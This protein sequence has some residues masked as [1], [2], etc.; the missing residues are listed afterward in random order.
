MALE[1]P[2]GP[3]GRWLAALDAGEVPVADADRRELRQALTHIAGGAGA[4][5]DAADP[6]LLIRV[7]SASVALRRFLCRHPAAVAELSALPPVRGVAAWRARLATATARAGDEATFGAALRI[8][9]HRAMLG[10]VARELVEGDPL[11]TGRD[12]SGLAEAALQVT[13]ERWAGWLRRSY[14]EPRLSDGT[15]CRPVVIA[16]GK[17]GGRELNLSSDIDL[18]YAYTADNGRTTGAGGLGRQVDLHTYFSRLF[19]KV[20]QTLAKETA[21]GL[22]FR[23]D[24][25]L[26]PEGRT[27]PVCNSVDG[28]ERYYESFG[29]PWER[30]AWIK[31]RAV[32]GDVALGEA[33]L[34][35]LAPFV[36]RKHLDHHFLG[37]IASMRRRIDARGA[38]LVQRD[39]FDV[40][41]GRGGIREVEFSVQTLQLTWGGKDPALRAVDTTR[42]IASLTAAGYIEAR[43]GQA[44]AAAYRF[45]RR[46]E[47]ALQLRDDRQVQQLGGDPGG[48]KRVAVALGYAPDDQGLAAFEQ[49]LGAHRRAARAAFDAIAAAPAATAADDARRAWEIAF[50][51]ALDPDV[52]QAS[53]LTAVGELG[54]RDAATAL[55]HLDA[56]ARRP[57]SPF[58]PLALARGGAVARKLLHAV[59]QTPDPTAALGH[60]AGLLRALRHRRAALDQLDQDPRRL[61]LLTHLFGTSHALSRRI[62]RSPGLLDRLVFDGAEPSVRSARGM[63]ALLSAEPGVADRWEGALGAVRR[64]HQAETLRIGYFDLAGLLDVGAVGRQLSDLADVLVSRVAAAAAAALD[65]PGDALGIVALGRLGGRELGYGSPIELLFT[66]GA[67]LGPAEAARL[68]RRVVTGLSC[69]TPEGSLYSVEARLRL[70]GHSGPP[71]VTREQ[72]AALG[73]RAQAAAW[74][75]RGVLEAR[76]VLGSAALRQAVEAA[77]REVLGAFGD[78]PAACARAL[79][80][81]REAL[82]ASV[83]GPGPAL[84]RG[85]LDDLVLAIRRAQLTLP[86]RAREQARSGHAAGS[87]NAAEAIRGLAELGVVDATRARGC[88][89]AGAF[90]AQLENRL[91]IVQDRPTGAL[92]LLDAGQTPR[93]TAALT[94]LAIR[95]GYGDRP[96]AQAAV[97]LQADYGRHRATIVDCYERM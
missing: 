57:D 54:L 84:R 8:A 79:D 53:R 91:C 33:L 72:L 82:L 81:G 11:A 22:V 44:L 32:A 73:A 4:A 36:W 76:V 70:R 31:A 67:E 93:A 39:G 43:Q 26:R 41:L 25:D 7:L 92:R 80:Q 64:L 27:G 51:L 12:L 52:E 87:A 94:R 77:R 21:E 75:G 42:A 68:A 86:P 18:V 56:L 34:E 38:R 9:R 62:V 28:L 48:R 55:R 95:M 66:H 35:R 2:A 50:S 74:D 5:A 78:A 89:E 58:H 59:C 30:V 65:L 96:G 45:L 23:V 10:V 13:L 61:R 16:I 37:E 6:A 71:C 40:K 20:G 19:V 29:H 47:H 83:D 24:L 97:A 88:A 1:A 63:E 90:L 3:L 69:T 17:L 46:V 49:A 14:G 15:L 85:G 60:L